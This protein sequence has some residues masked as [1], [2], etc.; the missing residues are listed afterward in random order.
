M[1]VSSAMSTQSVSFCGSEIPLDQA[2]DECF[3]QLQGTLN[4]LHC[5][6][7]EIAMMADQD[8]DYIEG[9]K[10]TLE[11]S[12]SIDEMV[13][14]FTELKSV[15]KQVIGK[16]DESE[17]AEAKRIIDNHKLQKKI[18]KDKEKAEKAEEKAQE[19]TLASLAKSSLN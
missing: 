5:Y 11:I 12:E 6:T 8:A 13:A 18:I 15:V 3:V 10:K 17:K 1:S 19:K 4:G 2:L 16:P 9:L 14:L 7:R